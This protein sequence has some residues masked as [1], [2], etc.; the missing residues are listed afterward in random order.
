MIASQRSHSQGFT[1]IE[2]L[3][4]LSIIAIALTA[5]FKATSE[6][7]A[8]TSRLKEKSISHWVA[9]QGVASI[10]L[11]LVPI[12]PHQDITQVTTMLGQ[13]WYWRA[14]L[15]QT[16]IA[17]MQRILVTVSQKPAGPFTDPLLAFRYVP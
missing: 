3:I 2:V 8:I 7:I 11:N 16:S 5:L 10:Q 12:V 6:N 14:K 17:K 13:R 4:A 1:L 15:S 9:M